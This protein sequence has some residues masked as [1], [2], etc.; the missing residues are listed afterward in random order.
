LGESGSRSAG[1]LLAQDIVSSQLDADRLDYLLRDSHMT[2][3][4][5]GKIDLAWILNVMRPGHARR[6]GGETGRR[7]SAAPDRRGAFGVYF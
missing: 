3:V 1:D 6:R 7:E 4:A 2:G 5:Y